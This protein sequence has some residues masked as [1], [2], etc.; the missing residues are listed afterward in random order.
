[1]Q[2][3]SDNMQFE[4]AAMMR[5]RIADLSQVLQQQSMDT[6]ADV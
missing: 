4:Q 3:Y 6:V 2:S 5:D 1:M